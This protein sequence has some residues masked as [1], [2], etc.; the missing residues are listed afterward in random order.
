[1]NTQHSFLSMV[2]K[3]IPGH[4]YVSAAL[5]SCLPLLV[6]AAQFFFSS[7]WELPLPY[8]PSLAT[9]PSKC[10]THSIPTHLMPSHGAGALPKLD[11]LTLRYAAFLGCRSSWSLCAYPADSEQT[12]H[13]VLLLES[14]Q[15]CWPRA[16]W[17]LILQP[18][19]FFCRLHHIFP[20]TSLLYLLM[21]LVFFISF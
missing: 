7:F 14:L 1:M 5:N 17:A 3:W 19:L 4:M 16:F 11:P 2:M 21:Y 20:I 18:L 15:P 6:T 10:S 12:L 13:Q 9:C 8:A